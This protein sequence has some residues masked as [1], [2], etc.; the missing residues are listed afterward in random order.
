MI[1]WNVNYYEKKTFEMS[2]L[3]ID[4]ALGWINPTL[5]IFIKN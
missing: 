2:H 1:K 3:F 4:G 5:I